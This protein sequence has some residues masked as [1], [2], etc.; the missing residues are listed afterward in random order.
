MLL[1]IAV[2]EQT[3]KEV[4]RQAALFPLLS[5]PKQG[6]AAD[7]TD[8]TLMV[9]FSEL[10]YLSAIDFCDMD[11]FCPSYETIKGHVSRCGCDFHHTGL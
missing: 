9:N 11:R 4:S 2:C 8:E 3:P 5:A 10:S 1:I 6:L 7:K